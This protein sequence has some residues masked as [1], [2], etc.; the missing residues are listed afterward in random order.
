MLKSHVKAFGFDRRLGHCPGR[1]HMR[2]VDGQVLIVVPL[3][4]SSP[5]K[6]RVI[7]EQLDKW[8]ELGVIEPSISPCGAPVVI[9]YRNG[10]PRFCVNYRKLNAVTISDEFPLP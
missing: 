6:W 7:E 5:E 9:A 10:K 1:A 4:G 3:Y 2:T 8:L